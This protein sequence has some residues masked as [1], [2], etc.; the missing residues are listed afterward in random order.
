M[1]PS[2]VFVIVYC[3]DRFDAGAVN[4][5]EGGGGGGGGCCYSHL[6]VYYESERETSAANC[7][8]GWM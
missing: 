1:R 8:Y 3:G 7:R 5:L 4:R 2:F 6:N